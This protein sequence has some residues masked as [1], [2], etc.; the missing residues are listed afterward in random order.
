MRVP[1]TPRLDTSTMIVLADVI[2]AVSP[3]AGALNRRAANSQNTKPNAEVTSVVAMM[4]KLFRRSES[5]RAR[6]MN[7]PT[8]HQ[9]RR[10]RSSLTREATS[11][12]RLRALRVVGER[13]SRVMGTRHGAGPVTSQLGE[14]PNA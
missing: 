5:P 8:C 13:R 14:E 1:P 10:R 7:V 3:T 12:C 9:R 11:V 2:A 4:N 6:S